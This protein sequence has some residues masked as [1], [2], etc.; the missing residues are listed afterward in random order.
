MGVGAGGGSGGGLCLAAAALLA[1]VSA[2]AFDGFDGYY[3]QP[4][5]THRIR[6]HKG[7]GRRETGSG[8]LGNGRDS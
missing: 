3:Q 7:T 1:V 4:F 6:H 2:D 8:G 5:F